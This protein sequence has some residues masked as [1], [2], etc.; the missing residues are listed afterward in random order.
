MPTGTGSF[1]YSILGLLTHEPMSGYDIKRFLE[2]LGWLVGSPSYGS[3]YPALH[4]LLED[5]R[6]MFHE[7][8]GSKGLDLRFQLDGNLLQFVEADGA[9][10]R[11]AALSRSRWC[12][13]I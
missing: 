2:S 1:R 11:Q 12:R 10:V 7:L 13:S 4:A 5:V 6:L 9:R 8:A 3:I